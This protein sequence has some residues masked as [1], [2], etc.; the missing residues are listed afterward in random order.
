MA[1]IKF[2]N[3]GIT[4]MGACVPKNKVSNKKSSELFSDASLK[5]TIKITGVIERR[6]SDKKYCSSD[7]CFEA[8]NHLLNEM[9]VDRKS[10]DILIFVTQTPDY[11]IPSTS[12]VLQGRL[13]L[14]KSTACFDINLGCSG[15]VYGLSVAY[16]YASQE[17]I[18]KVLLLVGDTVTK[19]VSDKDKTTSLLFGDGGTATL[20]EKKDEFKE[21]FFSLNSDGSRNDILKIKAGGYRNQSS[22]ETLLPKVKEQGNIRSDEQLFMDGTEIFN[23]TIRE[24]PRDIRNLIKFSNTEI[25]NIDFIVYHQANKFITDYLTKK[26]NYPLERVPYS[27]NKYG[28]TS[29][30]SIPLTILSELKDNIFNKK[31]ILCGFG[32]GLSWASALLDFNKLHIENIRYL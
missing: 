6:I 22:C 31:L 11:R 12:I 21:S 4:G 23:F 17:N 16:S 26:L 1:F 25:N 9:N 32:V 20:I 2:K 7:Y 10:I 24:V 27:L 19:F 29:C 28:N 14:E 13:G 5:K 18:Q 30:A 8:A 15:Y 3:V